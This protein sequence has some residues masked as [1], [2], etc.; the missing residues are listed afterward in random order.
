M[1]SPSFTGF[2]VN[3]LITG[4]G[5]SMV[6]GGRG[7]P[8]VSLFPRSQSSRSHLIPQNPWVVRIFRAVTFV[9]LVYRCISRHRSADLVRDHFPQLGRHRVVDGVDDAIH[10][11]Q[12]VGH[13]GLDTILTGGEPNET[14]VELRRTTPNRLAPTPTDDLSRA[15]TEELLLG[16]ATPHQRPPR[17]TPRDMGRLGWRP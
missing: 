9:E 11:E 10:L 7:L 5:A 3:S 15:S 16:A 17:P 6:E 13:A 1:S 4:D 12:D 8:L 2:G 14:V